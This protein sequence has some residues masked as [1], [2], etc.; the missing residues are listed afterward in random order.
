L[1][2][3]QGGQLPFV[4]LRRYTETFVNFRNGF[5]HFSTHEK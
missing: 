3:K 1:F 2:F 5:T 4:N